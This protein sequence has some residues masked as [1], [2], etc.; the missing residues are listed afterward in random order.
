MLNLTLFFGVVSIISF[1]VYNVLKFKNKKTEMKA[2][3]ERIVTELIVDQQEKSV[4]DYQ[5]ITAKKVAEENGIDYISD[6][7]GRKFSSKDCMVNQIYA[8]KGKYIL[9][10]PP[11]DGMPTCPIEW[12][13]K[14]EGKTEKIMDN[15]SSFKNITNLN[16]I[17]LQMIKLYEKY[18]D[19]DMF[20]AS[21][22][23]A[24]KLEDEVCQNYCGRAS[25]VLTKDAIRNNKV[26]TEEVLEAKKYFLN[27]FLDHF[28][29][30]NFGVVITGNPELEE[31]LKKFNELVIKKGLRRYA[32]T[33]FNVW[34]SDDVQ[35]YELN[36]E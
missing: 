4:R 2:R 20:I 22:G 24:I 19:E 27:D 11:N 10:T 34:I 31:E 8:G 9:L 36:K 35:H 25:F 23:F 6:A 26:K 33:G 18:I 15:Q 13:G 12:Y 16:E 1:S 32:G 7:K 17:I 5:M 21:A 29:G 30:W 28:I 3:E 14:F